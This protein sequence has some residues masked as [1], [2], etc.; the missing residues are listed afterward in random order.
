MIKNLFTK[1][2][3][4]PVKG[5]SKEQAVQA[6]AAFWRSRQ[7]GVSFTSPFSFQAVQFQSKLG[8]RQSVV[9]QAVDEGDNTGVDLTFSAELTDEG[10]AVGAVGAVL[11]LPAAALVGAVSYAEYENDAQRLMSEFWS[12]IYALPRDAAVEHGTASDGPQAGGQCPGC[13]ATQDDDA[14]YC[15]YCGN[16]L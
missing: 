12:R 3:H 13:G 1:H 8:L 6:S 7:F 15:K 14:K 10:A 5:I 16:R 4:R 9:V 11:V 2:D